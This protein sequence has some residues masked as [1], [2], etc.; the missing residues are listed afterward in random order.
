MS[1]GYAVR[2]AMGNLRPT[3]SAG[4]QWSSI[5]WHSVVCG[6]WNVLAFRSSMGNSPEG[7]RW[8][9]ACLDRRLLPV[10]S[11]QVAA[12]LREFG[13]SASGEIDFIRFF[14]FI[15]QCPLANFRFSV[16]LKVCLSPSVVSVSTSL[17][18]D[19]QIAEEI[20]L[21]TSPRRA[22]TQY[23]CIQFCIYFVSVSRSVCL[24]S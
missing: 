6:L 2:D 8:L 24:S 7:P 16:F 11:V 3:C 21:Y 4:K 17:W 1:K 10:D 12:L 19:P 23:V 15:V 9:N 22:Y 5:A 14:I 18:G 13:V 20:S